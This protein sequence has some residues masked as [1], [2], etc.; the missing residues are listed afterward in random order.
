MA[1]RKLRGASPRFPSSRLPPT[2]PLSPCRASST[3]VSAAQHTLGLLLLLLRGMLPRRTRSLLRCPLRHARLLASR[4]APWTPADCV[5][6]KGKR[7]G[8]DVSSAVFS[9]K[10]W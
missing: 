4:L 2:L 3:T 6:R 7:M 8:P 1:G 9:A 10:G 5:D